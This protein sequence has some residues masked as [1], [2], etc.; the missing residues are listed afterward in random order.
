MV[1]P[2]VCDSTYSERLVKLNMLP[3]SFW[4]DYLD[5]TFLFKIIHGQGNI[6]PDL[7]PRRRDSTRATRSNNSNRPKFYIRRCK[8]STFQKSYFNRSIRTWSFLADILIFDT[9]NLRTFQRSLIIDYYLPDRMIL[10]I[11]VHGKQSVY[12]VIQHTILGINPL[13]VSNFI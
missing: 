6:D 2:F 9:P 12:H 1:L 11:L 7:I 10:V 4:H 8:T 5:V 13:A 3:L